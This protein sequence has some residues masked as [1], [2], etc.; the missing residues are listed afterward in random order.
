MEISRIIIKREHIKKNEKLF[1]QRVSIAMK[2]ECLV[3]IVEKH[4]RYVI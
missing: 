3:A 4:E 2:M 1:Y